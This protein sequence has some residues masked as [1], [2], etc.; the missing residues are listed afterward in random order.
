MDTTNYFHGLSS[1]FSTVQPSFNFVFRASFSQ[2]SI[3]SYMNKVND[4]GDYACICDQQFGH[5]FDLFL[6]SSFD[7]TGNSVDL[8]ANYVKTPRFRVEF[9]VLVVHKLRIKLQCLCIRI[10]LLRLLRHPVRVVG[11][12]TIA[13]PRNFRN[14]MT[15]EPKLTPRETFLTAFSMEKM[16]QDCATPLRSSANPEKT[17]TLCTIRTCAFMKQRQKGVLSFTVMAGVV[18]RVPSHFTARRSRSNG[19]N[20]DGLPRENQSGC[21]GRRIMKLDGKDPSVTACQKI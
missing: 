11:T 15:P 21:Q 14:K 3:E 1:G 10:P 13:I 16:K 4:T 8:P 9:Q 2:M 17:V 18:A 6:V 7:H 20:T 19:T 5:D 12:S